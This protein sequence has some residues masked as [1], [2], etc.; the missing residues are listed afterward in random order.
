M[1]TSPSPMERV[2]GAAYFGGAAVVPI[3]P[4]HQAIPLHRVPMLPWTGLVRWWSEP[5][6]EVPLDLTKS[7]TRIQS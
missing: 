7:A 5:L 3:A 1:E 6:Q 2:Q 4:I